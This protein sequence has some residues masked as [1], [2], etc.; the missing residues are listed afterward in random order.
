MASLSRL[1]AALSVVA[2]LPS[3]AA[4]QSL[5]PSVVGDASGPVRAVASFALVVASGGV[6]L[7]RS[8]DRVHRALD[9]LLARPSRAVPYGLLAY[10][11]VLAVGLYGLSQLIR[12]GV[13]STVLG[14]AAAILLVVAVVFVTGFGFLVVG[15]LLTDLQG[16]R[17]PRYGLLIGAALSAGCWAVL[18]LL[19]GVVVSAVV[20]SF[21]IGGATRRWFHAERTVERE[22]AN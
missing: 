8:E 22:R 9:A 5:D 21:G 6:V 16:R 15:T 14:R 12:V 17:R 1:V 20:A 3:V 19:G 7:L 10:V 4:A 2:V 13:V 11:L 18:P